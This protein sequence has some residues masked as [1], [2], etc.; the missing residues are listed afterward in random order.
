MNQ[1]VCENAFSW[2]Q[3]ACLNL[4]LACTHFYYPPSSSPGPEERLPLLLLVFLGPNMYKN[5][6]FILCNQP[7]GQRKW[8]N[9]SQLKK[10]TRKQLSLEEMFHLQYRSQREVETFDMVGLDSG[11]GC[12]HKKAARFIA[13]AS[14]GKSFSWY[15]FPNIGPGVAV[16]EWKF[17]WTNCRPS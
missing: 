11:S 4:D 2:I 12:R 14:V 16:K 9:Y 1:I 15:L 17:P 8:S 7:P 13:W 3:V 5:K 10:L 6:W